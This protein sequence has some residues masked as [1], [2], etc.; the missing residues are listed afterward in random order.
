MEWSSHTCRTRGEILVTGR[1]GVY[2]AP[3][4]HLRQSVLMAAAEHCSTYLPQ[5]SHD[6][7][8]LVGASCLQILNCRIALK[9]SSRQATVTTRRPSA[10]ESRSLRHFPPHFLLR[11]LRENDQVAL[12]LTS[13]LP[14]VPTGHLPAYSE[15]TRHR[16]K[17]L[18]QCRPN[19]QDGC[20]R[21]KL[22]T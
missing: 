11:R 7:R 10:E 17:V 2:S 18:S 9:N 16:P 8:E 21:M 13:F 14:Q 5:W 12:F 4:R 3:D 15:D 22:V 1:H 19:R 20:L 6:R